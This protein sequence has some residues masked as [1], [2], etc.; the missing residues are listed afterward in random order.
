MVA[1]CFT[2]IYYIMRKTLTLISFLFLS[3][4][5]MAQN[6]GIRYQEKLDS[7]VSDNGD[8]ARFTYDEQFR[9]VEKKVFQNDRLIRKEVTKYAE[10]GM[11]SDFCVYEE[12]KRNDEIVFVP[13]HRKVRTV[14]DNGSCIEIKDSVEVEGQ[15]KLVISTLEIFDYDENDK[16]ITCSTSTY[17]QKSGG[18]SYNRHQINY[19]AEGNKTN[20]SFLYPDYAYIMEYKDGRLYVQTKSV[21]K[22]GRMSIV[23]STVREY[24]ESGALKCKYSY[25]YSGIIFYMKDYV[26]YDENGEK[27]K[28]QENQQAYSYKYIRDEKGRVKEIEKYPFDSEKIISREVFY[29][30][31]LPIDSAYYT[32]LYSSD[33]T[34]PYA[35]Y[36]YI[37]N[38]IV[39][40]EVQN[41]YSVYEKSASDG[42]WAD[43]MVN[44]NELSHSYGDKTVFAH[45]EVN[46]E[47]VTFSD[48][49]LTTFTDY[50]K[51]VRKQDNGVM[52]GE[53]DIYYDKSISGSLIAGLDEK[54]KV[55]HVI[56][57]D[58]DGNEVESVY[59]YASTSET[60]SIARISPT[61]SCNPSVYNLLG[62]RLSYPQR[63]INI[64]DGR[65]IMIGIR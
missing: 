31:Q 53:K 3:V 35:K 50:G 42:S 47:T 45:Y 17:D 63:G 22:D 57:R 21:N 59:F 10:D 39:D 34:E 13:V 2:K 7:I 24:Y 40:G 36:Y 6:D 23:E 30:D 28:S 61:R 56:N 55:S 33:A 60:S 26:L 1:F 52:V 64:I 41:G 62:Q 54:Y 16:L 8:I 5:L 9:V 51:K 4:A 32:L 11:Y 29:Y 48:Y 49:T 43:S 25:D 15:E 38:L 14:R 20:E 58:A 65:K 44:G 37:P 18:A 19:D 46:D 12:R 27:V